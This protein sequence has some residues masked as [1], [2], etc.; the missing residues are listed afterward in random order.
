MAVEDMI[1]KWCEFH[2]GMKGGSGGS[3]DEKGNGHSAG[4]HLTADFLHLVEGRGDEAAYA[5]Y[6]GISPGRFVKY[7]FLLDHHA[8]VHNFESVARKDYSCYV[9]SDVVH[10]PLYRSV[11]NQRFVGDFTLGRRLFF[12]HVRFK[13]GDGVPHYLGG[14]HNLREEHLPVSEKL[15]YFFHSGHEGPFDHLDGLAVFAQ[16]LEDVGF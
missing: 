5:Y 6:S 12:L 3:S 7:P 9:L 11:D 1:V 10:V 13:D 14:L 15:P 4:S 2:G 16:A 8:E